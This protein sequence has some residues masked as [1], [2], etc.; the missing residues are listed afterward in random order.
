MSET[1]RTNDPL[2]TIVAN[3]ILTTCNSDKILREIANQKLDRD[4]Q[5][6]EFLIVITA[7]AISTN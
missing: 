6:R 3:K 2:E 1:S 5:I 7:T 4:L